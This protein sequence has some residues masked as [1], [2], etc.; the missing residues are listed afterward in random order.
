M[1]MPYP[2]LSHKLR[3]S[4]RDL[5]RAVHRDATRTFVVEGVRACEALA[6]AALRPDLVIIRQDADQRALQVATT[7]AMLGVDVVT[8][9]TRDMELMCDAVTPQDVM[10]V[11][12]FPAERPLGDRVVVL[13]GIADPGNAGT[14]VRT[15][16]WFGFTDV[17]FLSGCV[18][19]FHPKVVRSTV[20]THARIN[21]LRDASINAFRNAWHERGPIVAAVVDSGVTPDSVDRS[22]SAVALLIGGEANGLSDAA[23]DAAT[24]RLTIPGSGDVESLNAA[25]A[26]AILCYEFRARG[27]S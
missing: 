8:A 3:T 20:G 5:Q 11:V 25:V 1:S 14:I 10:A 12:P 2:P 24:I 26:A 16:A 4:V 17:V 22:A 9:S 15:A 6:G 19:P 18:D 7:M 13:D 27:G 21:V 23:L